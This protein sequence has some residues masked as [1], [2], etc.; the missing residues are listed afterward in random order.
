MCLLFET[1]RVENGKPLHLA[2]HEQRMR[3]AREEFWPWSNQSDLKNLIVIPSEFST[4]MVRCNILYGPETFEI[5]FQSYSRRIIRSLKLVHC[6]TVDYHVKFVD[7]I[8]LEKLLA[9]RGECDDILIVK[10]GLIT[11]TSVSNIIFYDGKTWV[12]PEKP[13]LKGTCRE[14]L[15]GEGK[16]AASGINEDELHR[17]TGCKLINAMRFPEEEETIMIS[18]IFGGPG[19]IG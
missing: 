8:N 10:E 19:A 11:D 1:I 2:W 15:L 4:G 6:N 12:T 16:I 13:L 18:H 7:R 5:K 9:M 14:R 17:F 3:R